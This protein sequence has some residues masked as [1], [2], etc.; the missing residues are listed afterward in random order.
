MIS[1]V[2]SSSMSHWRRSLNGKTRPEWYILSIFCFFAELAAGCAVHI[3][4]TCLACCIFNDCLFE[5][6][7]LQSPNDIWKCN[8]YSLSNISKSIWYKDNVNRLKVIWLSA[9]SIYGRLYGTSVVIAAKYLDDTYYT[10]QFYADVIRIERKVF[11]ALEFQLLGLLSFELYTTPDDFE[12][13]R[14]IHRQRQFAIL[15]TKEH[16]RSTPPRHTPLPQPSRQPTLPLQSPK[17]VFWKRSN[18]DYQ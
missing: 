12:M 1:S 10:N 13:I 16:L 9:S 8:D 15:F 11:N 17:R 18:M 14:E 3:L 2:K 4:A 7:D 6:L 5:I